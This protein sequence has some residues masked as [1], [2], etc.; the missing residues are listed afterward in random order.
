MLREAAQGLLRV[1]NTRA[2]VESGYPTTQNRGTEGQIQGDLPYLSSLG[3]SNSQRQE[4]EGRGPGLGVGERRGSCL[5]GTEFQLG[6]LEKFR[7]RTAVMTAR[8]RE[9]T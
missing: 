9:C 8:R 2:A 1:E 7:R 3:G 6:E 4:A 5:M